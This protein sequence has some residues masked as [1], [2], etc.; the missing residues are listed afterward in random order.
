MLD[1]VEFLPS[2]DEVTA[3]LWDLE[4]LP[5]SILMEQACDLRRQ[6]HGQRIS[7]S[8]KVFIPLTR[9]CR[10]ACRYCS[11]AKSPRSLEKIFLSPDDVMS[12][13]RAGVDAGCSEALFT[14]GDHP[15]LRYPDARTALSAFHHDSTISYLAEISNAVQEKT[16]LLSHINAGILTTQEITKLRRVSAS[17][18]TMLETTSQRLYRKGGPHYGCMTKE[19]RL[20]IG[21]LAAAGEHDVPFTTGILVGIGETQF[22]RIESLLTIRN[23]H[24]RF[25][26]IQ[27][28]IVQ[29][30]LAKPDTPM[31]GASEPEMDDLLWTIA[32][33]RII[34]GPAM[35]IQAPPNL[36]FERFPQL[37]AA[38]IDDW[39]GVSPITPDF[40]NPEASWP[41]LERLRAATNSVRLRACCALTCLSR[42]PA[43]RQALAR[44]CGA[45]SRDPRE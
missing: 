4:N 19:P 7:F 8:P 23:L 11:F 35:H 41:R 25:G 27:E 43:Q 9:L 31:R 40:V 6:G 2:A 44:S 39:G 36:S 32:S 14:L 20:R 3:R 28:V 34:F 42:I 5:L 33:A 24:L 15:E 10:D 1:P 12:L 17:L 37:L 16:G 29:K 13:A 26:H 30:F 45:P 22:E 18:G 38:G 21:T